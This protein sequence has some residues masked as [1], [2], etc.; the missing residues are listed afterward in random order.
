MHTIKYQK[1]DFTLRPLQEIVLPAYKGSTFRGVFGNAFKKIV[2]ALKLKE[3]KECMLKNQ[4][5]YSYVFE[6]PLPKNL[7]E[8]KRYSDIPRPF[9]M[10][11]P[12]DR[13]YIYGNDDDIKFSL[14]LVGKAC[15]YLPYFILAFKEAGQIG[16]GKGRGKYSLKSVECGNT[17]V[18]S[19]DN[20]LLNKIEPEIITIDKNQNN[21]KVEEVKI[22]FLTPTRIK[23]RGML[24]IDI[25]FALFARE[26]SKRIGLLGFFHNEWESDNLT[27]NLAEFIQNCKSIETV[28]AKLKWIDWERYSAKQNTRMTLG[29]FTG[30]IKFL[31]ELDKFMKI[32]KAGEIL[33]LGKGTTF[34]LGKYEI[35]NN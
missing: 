26:L 3:C 35:H 17:K 11:P 29:G 31:G 13:K 22:K 2:C 28:D 34:G 7:Q 19:D 25:D 5:I 20:E 32:I 4:C 16:I 23:T 8:Y 24:T 18:Y 33:H 21:I 15:N 10:E 12:L 27:D 9:I 30:E 1:F 14:V 6:T